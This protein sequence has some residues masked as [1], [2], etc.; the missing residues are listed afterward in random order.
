MPLSCVE[1]RINCFWET[2]RLI[3]GFVEDNA[4]RRSASHSSL[5]R[6]L[7][8]ILTSAAN[9]LSHKYVDEKGKRVRTATLP[10][11]SYKRDYLVQKSLRD[12]A[13]KSFFA[14]ELHF[15]PKNV[16]CK[17]SERVS[18][19]IQ[20]GFLVIFH[21]ASSR[22]SKKR[23]YQSYSSFKNLVVGFHFCLKPTLQFGFAVPKD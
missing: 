16:S 12:I 5:L 17:S 20:K 8:F 1:W 23:K 22:F 21:S 19:L 11:F 7:V 3:P 14:V 10:T 9:P 13:S 18:S 15:I 2:S 6:N 4:H